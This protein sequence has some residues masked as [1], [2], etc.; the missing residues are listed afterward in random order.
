MPLQGADCPTGHA[1][2]RSDGATLAERPRHLDDGLAGDGRVRRDPTRQL[3]RRTHAGADLT[4][5]FP[6]MLAA[7]FTFSH[8]PLAMQATISF[9]AGV[10]G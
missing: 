9:I 6:S 3:A 5:L 10:L 7:H 4:Q 8:S 1:D 2:A